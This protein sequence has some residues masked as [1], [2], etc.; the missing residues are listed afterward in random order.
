MRL[1]LALDLPNE[2]KTK[3]ANQ[4]ENF[5]KEYPYFRWVSPENYHVTLQFFGEEFKPE[6]LINKISEATYDKR[7]FYLYSRQASLFMRGKIIVYLGFLRNKEIE[8]IVSDI[9][10]NLGMDT[11][12]RFEPH[13]TLAR[14][15]IPS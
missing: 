6:K 13:L 11:S 8:N 3:L 12:K 4:I 5:Q 7:E 9:R 2:A 1:F 10:E 15:K 14:Y